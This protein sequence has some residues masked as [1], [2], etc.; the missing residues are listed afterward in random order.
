MDC[1]VSPVESDTKCKSMC[2]FAMSVE[3]RESMWITGVDSSTDPARAHNGD[4]TPASRKPGLFCQDLS[5]YKRNSLH[6]C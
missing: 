6:P 5:D 1:S 3:F 4:E 2:L